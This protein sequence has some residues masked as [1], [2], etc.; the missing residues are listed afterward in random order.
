MLQPHI[1]SATAL[2][3]YEK[4][5]EMT[6]FSGRQKLTLPEARKVIVDLKFDALYRQVFI[7]SLQ[8]SD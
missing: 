4:L 8:K 6:V 1:E 2:S 7:E 3:D 5:Q